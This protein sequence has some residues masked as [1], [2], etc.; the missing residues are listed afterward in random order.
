MEVV[1]V[2]TVGTGHALIA[3][4]AVWLIT[5]AGLL[6]MTGAHRAQVRTM[7][8]VRMPGIDDVAGVQRLF[9]LR[10]L[11]EELT[12]ADQKLAAGKLNT[13]QHE[14]VVWRV[15]DRVSAVPV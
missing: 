9:T 13:V 12:E 14:A 5:G 10:A 11:V 4:T 1:L 2:P 3:S 7:S 15:Y 6:G 8:V